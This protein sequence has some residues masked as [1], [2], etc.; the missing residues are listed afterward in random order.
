MLDRHD[1]E[2]AK[3]L[4][5]ERLEAPYVYGGMFDPYNKQQGTDCS[6]VWQDVLATA[7][8]NLIWGREAQGA[9]TEDYRYIPVGGVGPFGTVRVASPHDFPPDAA[10][11]LAFHH[12]GNGGAA[13]HMWGE[14]DGMRIES[15]GSKGLVTQP[16]AWPV[17]HPYANAW[18]YL[19]GPISDLSREDRYALATIKEGRR[20]GISRKGI[21]IAL[22]VELVETNLTM[23]ANS[24]VPESLNFPHDAVGS[25]HDSTGLFQQ[26]QAW[27]P[28]SETMDPTLS[29]RLFFLGGHAGQRGLT[30]FPYNSDARTPGGWAQAVQVSAFP[31]RYDERWA[32]AQEIYDRLVGLTKE[33]GPLMAL[34]EQE[35]RELLDGVRY[36]RAQLGPKDPAWSPASSFGVDADGNELTFRDGMAALKRLTD[37]QAAVMLAAIAASNPE[38]LQDY[39]DKNRGDQ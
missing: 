5:R 21:C 9:T 37:T 4:V 23:Y 7:T 31:D 35:Q 22:S 38:V 16:E 18:A 8:G 13:S 12:E 39:I 11:K 19:P 27:G 2:N 34:S 26:R 36:V 3:N 24:N 14:L 6:G 28:L 33:E 10:A 17:D 20:L 25:D 30:D 15:A 32:E 29:A 1:V